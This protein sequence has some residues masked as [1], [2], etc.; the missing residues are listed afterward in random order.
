MIAAS[1]SATA[2]DAFYFY[3]KNGNII[4][5][6]AANYSIYNRGDVGALAN[7]IIDYTDLQGTTEAN[8]INC[9]SQGTL[10]SSTW[11]STPATAK[12][13]KTNYGMASVDQT[14]AATTTYI[15]SLLSPASAPATGRVG[16]TFATDYKDITTKT[17]GIIFAFVDASNFWYATRKTLFKV[18]AGVE[19]VVATWT[20]VSDGDRM[21]IDINATSTTV[22]KYARDG[23]GTLSTLA[24]NV[25]GP[26][27]VGKVGL[28][29]KYS[30][31]G[32]L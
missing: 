18:V 3:D 32:A 17:H 7:F 26:T 16:V 4:N 10:S 6:F 5:N 14:L 9:V 20:R 28:I 2:T 30:A 21:I 13:W 23:I 12:L 19:S 31:T 11:A 27:V 1:T 15:Y 29:Q 25:N 8:L 24:L 22:Y